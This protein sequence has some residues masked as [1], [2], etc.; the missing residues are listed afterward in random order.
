MQPEKKTNH[1]WEKHNSESEQTKPECIL[2]KPQTFVQQGSGV[3]IFVDWNDFIFHFA[4]N[5][6][7]ISNRKQSFQNKPGLALFIFEVK[8]RNCLLFITKYIFTKSQLYCQECSS[9]L[10]PAG[11]HIAHAL[12]Q[13]LVS[14]GWSLELGEK[15]N[16][17]KF[18]LQSE[19]SK[20]GRGLCEG[21]FQRNRESEGA[22]EDKCGPSCPFTAPSGMKVVCALLQVFLVWKD[23]DKDKDEEGTQT[24]KE[25]NDGGIGQNG[26]TTFYRDIYSWRKKAIK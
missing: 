1:L 9:P 24:E 5:P 22:L 12:P 25:E 17:G 10:L 23:E 20:D 6:N 13:L 14:F 8:L 18:P 16:D 21:I 15:P 11:V 3:G 7:W 26:A 2:E 19:E 4:L